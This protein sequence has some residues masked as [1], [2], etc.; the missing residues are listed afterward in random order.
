MQVVN[1][2]EME[3]RV[4]ALAGIATHGKKPKKGFLWC[5]TRGLSVLRSAGL[6]E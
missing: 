5:W 3:K 4:N 6:E 1:L 2:G